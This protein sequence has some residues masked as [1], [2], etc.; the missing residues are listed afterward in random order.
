MLPGVELK[1]ELPTEAVEDVTEPM[2]DEQAN[3]VRDNMDIDPSEF[4]RAAV[5]EANPTEIEAPPQITDDVFV[6]IQLPNDIP[7]VDI[8]Q[9]VQAVSTPPPI[10]DNTRYN[11]HHEHP[12]PDDNDQD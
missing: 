11:A 6:N 3:A 7:G 1:S 12:E 8:D 10:Q 9:D 2:Q 4:R 5:I